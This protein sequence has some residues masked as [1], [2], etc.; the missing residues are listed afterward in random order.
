MTASS[1]VVVATTTPHRVL[2]RRL[3]QLS[4][5]ALTLRRALFG[6]GGS[7]PLPSPLSPPEALS[8]PITCQLVVWLYQVS[9][10]ELIG[11]H[12]ANATYGP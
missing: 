3:L 2:G 11:V 7:L 6:L 8:G 5:R 9:W 12:L 1:G 10:L 4:R